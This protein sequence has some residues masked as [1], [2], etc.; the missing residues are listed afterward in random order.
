LSDA[1]FGVV[2]CWVVDHKKYRSKITRQS[3]IKNMLSKQKILPGIRIPNTK[4]KAKS[5]MNNPYLST[6][7]ESSEP[8]WYESIA[9]G[10]AVAALLRLLRGGPRPSSTPLAVVVASLLHV[11]PRIRNW[12]ATKERRASLHEM[13][14]SKLKLRNER[15]ES[16]RAD[17]AM[18]DFAAENE[19]C[20]LLAHELLAKM[21]TGELTCERILRAFCSRALRLGER[22]EAVT[23]ELYDEAIARA[24]EVDLIRQ[25]PGHDV[26]K[27]PPLLGLPVSFKDQ[28]NVK[29]YDSTA[30]VQVRVFSPATED[31]AVVALLREAGAIPFV[32]TNVPQSLM[33]TESHNRIF[34]RALNPWNL[35]RTP[36]GS[37][38]GEGAMVAMDASPLGVGTDIG[39][40]IRT[41]AAYCGIV[42]LKPSSG[43]VSRVGLMGARLQ[44]RNGQEGKK[45]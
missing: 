5:I 1:S 45:F 11:V 8:S 27:E 7:F 25:A 42:G 36:G 19:I 10:V 33:I 28:I 40:S 35:K 31:A 17:V 15:R 2:L 6:P 20:R 23:D 34:G 12:T 16:M 38:G 26:T 37:S 39:G 9:S 24:L 43:R 44:Q 4:Y 30:G 14:A 32:K 41:P 29:G 21:R 13:S 22:T 18:S 3:K